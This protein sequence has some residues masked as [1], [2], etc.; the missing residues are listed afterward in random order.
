MGALMRGRKI[1][2]CLITVTLSSLPAVAAEDCVELFAAA[3]AAAGGAAWDGVE[4][5]RME[6]AVSTGGLKGTLKSWEDLTRGR[7]TNRVD[8]GV[9]KVADGFDGATPWSQDPSGDVTEQGSEENLRN[10]SNQAYLISRAMWYPERWAAEIGDCRSRQADGRT[11]EVVEVVPQGGRQ[12]EIWFDAETQLMARVADVEANVPSTLFLSDYREVEGLVVAYEIRMSTGET[13]YDTVVRV[14]SVTANPELPEGVFEIPKV[15]VDDFKIAGGAASTTIPF[16]LH[17]NHIYVEAQV[18]GRETGRF[19]VDTGGVNLLTEAAATRLGVGSEGAIQGRG[20]GEETVDI[21]V[22]RLSSFT[23]GGVTMLEP[24]FYVIPMA[25]VLAAEGVEFDGLIGFEVFKRFVVE[26]DYAGRKLT[27]TRPEAF[28]PGEGGTRIPFEFDDRTPVVEGAIASIPTTFS[29]DTGSR[30]TVDLFA[31]FVAANDL[32]RVLGPRFEALTGWGVGGG[33]R[34]KVA[35]ATTLTLGGFEIPGVVVAI[36]MQEKGAFADRYTGGNIGGGVL[37]RFTVTFDYANKVM[38]LEPNADFAE[39][40]H[41]D[42]SGMWIQ[43]KGLSFE[44]LDV[45]PGGAADDAGIG[46]GDRIDA[47]DGVPVSGLDLPEVR[48]QFRRSA[49]GTVFELAVD[50]DGDRTTARVV[51]KDMLA[52]S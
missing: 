25:D 29:I 17:N 6:A 40:E 14:E 48:A 41:Y 1:A 50:S 28:A 23:F 44:V 13:K 24:T 43:R 15:A 11:F 8:L 31:P 4:Q 51:L 16:T 5:L 52:E 46:V 19:L 7:S 2:A 34:S 27:L 26:I 22:A 32:E 35:P 21:G 39:P 30:S 10:A 9:V 42:R 36:G 20:V 47:I 3:K 37:K 49:P 12:L 18:N 45:V 38:I 33:V